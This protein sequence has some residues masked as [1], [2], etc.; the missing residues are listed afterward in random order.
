MH[1]VSAGL[2]ISCE[3]PATKNC[4][5]FAP[6]TNKNSFENVKL[7][8][9]YTAGIGESPVSQSKIKK[10]ITWTS[11]RY[12][13]VTHKKNVTTSVSTK[14]CLSIR[15]EMVKLLI[16]ILLVLMKCTELAKLKLSRKR[17]VVN[18]YASSHSN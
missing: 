1:E 13:D 3:H 8:Y 11:C 6:E 12:S 15:H 17:V 9:Y 14:N 10:K 5:K 4:T 16:D 2:W 7:F 18:V